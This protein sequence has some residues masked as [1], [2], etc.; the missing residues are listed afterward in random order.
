MNKLNIWKLLTTLGMGLLSILFLMPL[1]WMLS[2]A[3]KFEADVLKFPVEWIPHRWNIVE[4]FKMVWMGDVSFALYYYNSLKL[5]I[6]ATLLTLIISSM[7]GYSFAKLQFPFKNGL[8]MLLLAFFL[9]PAESTLVPRYILIKWFGIYDTHAAL[10]LMAAFSIPLTFL[11]RQF[12]IG[13]HSEFIEAA[14]IDGAG[15]FRIYL[16]II[17]PMAKP[18]LAT[19]GILK[20]LWTWNDY[21]NPLIFLISKDLFTIPLGLQSFSD[22]YGTSYAAIMM[23]AVSTIIPILIV[24]IIL[25][26]QVIKGITVGG[27]KG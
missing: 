26:K 24:F 23:A 2:A 17:L 7:A 1:L 10:I 15:H 9:V 20:F 21:Q 18:I 4:N 25:Q 14:K 16:Q 27:V 19:V 8:F 12:I 13:I 6:I 22:E 11:M 3:A 5:A